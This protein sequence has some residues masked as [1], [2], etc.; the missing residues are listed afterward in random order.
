MGRSYR[1]CY[2][3]CLSE[4]LQVDQEKTSPTQSLTDKSLSTLS[5][6]ITIIFSY[7]PLKKSNNHQQGNWKK[8]QI[9]KNKQHNNVNYP[10]SL[11][12]F[13]LNHLSAHHDDSWCWYLSTLDCS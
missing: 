10:L 5:A 8:T 11:F 1:T 3:T 2:H 12:R 6:S 9:E 13:T 4:S 7:R